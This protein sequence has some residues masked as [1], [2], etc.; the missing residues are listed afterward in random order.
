MVTLPVLT[1]LAGY[2]LVCVF[3]ILSFGLWGYLAAGLLLVFVG[4]MPAL[5]TVGRGMRA[6]RAKT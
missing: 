2:V 1:E 3:L 4:N 5:G 6:R